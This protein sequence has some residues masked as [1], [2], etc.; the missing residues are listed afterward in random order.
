MKRV[1]VAVFTLLLALGPA[2]AGAASA[3]LRVGSDI[4]YAPLEFYAPHSKRVQGFDYDLSQALAAK[5]GTTAAFQNHD[6][7]DLIKALNRGKYDLVISAMNDTRD[8]AR[9]VD[10]VDYFL[11]GSGILVPAGNPHHV[12]NLASLCGMTV[13][14]QRGTAQETALAA[15]S[16]QCAAIGLHPITVLAYATDDE[17]LKQ[18][19]A[20]KSMAHISDYPVVSHLARTLDGGKK[21]MVAG[22]QFGVVPYGI[23]VS[24]K[25]AALR[26]RV[27]AAL[28]ALIADGTYD[29]L[30]KKWGL[31]Q[32]AMRSAPINAGTKFQ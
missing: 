6:F 10:F 24:K 23:A 12:F 19:L 26:N 7:N 28:K 15:Q 22:Q 1:C 27:Q 25:N 31:E 32:G 20:G 14:L 2:A 21:Y 18:F 17:A 8:R 29:A 3:V 16:K 4:S 9:Q 13:D 5:M 30:L 11:A